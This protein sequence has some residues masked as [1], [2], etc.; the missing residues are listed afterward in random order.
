MIHR[1]FQVLGWHV[2]LYVSETCRHVCRIVSELYRM[3]CR[4]RKLS[5]AYCRLSLDDEPVIIYANRKKQR[6]VIAI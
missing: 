6:V 3:G 1:E 5:R 4:G 2:T